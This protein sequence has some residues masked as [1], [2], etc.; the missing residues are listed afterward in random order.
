M[1]GKATDAVGKLAIIVAVAF[2][3]GCK[4]DGEVGN[5]EIGRLIGGEYGDVEVVELQLGAETFRVFDKPSASKMIIT[6][7]M[8]WTL[9][10]GTAWTPKE[11]FEAAAA[12]YLANTGR[13]SCRVTETSAIIG[14]KHEIK[15]NCTPSGSPAAAKPK[16]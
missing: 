8:S 16:R 1:A 7:G 4:T 3:G 14:P 5:G 9:V 13:S 2:L 12:Q 15:Y 11:P 6:K 10:H